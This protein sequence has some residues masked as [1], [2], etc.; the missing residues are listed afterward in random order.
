M[1]PSRVGAHASIRRSAVCG[2]LRC[3]DALSAMVFSPV[4]RLATTRLKWSMNQSHASFAT[5]SSVPGSSNRCVAPGTTVSSHLP[6]Y[7]RLRSS[8]QLED[9]FVASAHDQQR[10]R[11]DC[12]PGTFP[13]DPV[14]RRERRPPAT[15]TL[16]SVAAT[17][18]APAPV[19]APK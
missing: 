7:R 4:Y 17:S 10:R 13:R 19:L 3:P 12:P 5:C 15:F 8:I 6:G 16:G 11:S 14:G 9:H 1:Q 18:A 2:T